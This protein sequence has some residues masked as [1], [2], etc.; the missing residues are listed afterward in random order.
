MESPVLFY[1]VCNILLRLL[2]KSFARTQNLLF[3]GSLRVHEFGLQIRQDLFNRLLPF[4]L[5]LFL[6]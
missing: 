4:P 2:V 6:P 3:L 5:P 1:L